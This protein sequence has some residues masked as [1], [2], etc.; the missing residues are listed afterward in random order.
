M[1]K[2]LLDVNVVLDVLLER[3]GHAG[4]AAVLWR[5]VEGGAAVG[6]IPAH[7]LTTVYYLARRARGPTFARRIVEELLTV[8]RAARVDEQVLRHA[9]A[10]SW[11]DFEDAVC[12][13]S[14]VVAGCD[15]IATRDP[16]GFRKAPLPVLDPG[17]A[18]AWLAS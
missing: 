2:L 10:L 5:A 13:A 15:A 6:Y 11:P 9:L 3:P 1:K 18:V 14:A 4:S 16:A 12:A 7:G 8:F 17:A